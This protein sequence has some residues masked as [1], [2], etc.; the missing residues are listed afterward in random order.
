MARVQPPDHT[1]PSRGGLSECH[2]TRLDPLL[3]PHPRNPTPQPLLGSMNILMSVR[4]TEPPNSVLATILHVRCRCYTFVTTYLAQEEARPGS[5][6]R[7]KHL[8]FSCHQ[9][10]SNS[11]PVV[12]SSIGRFSNIRWSALHAGGQPNAMLS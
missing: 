4:V 5:L 10:G 11:M 12:K 3:A 6:L 7:G 1:H 8:I 9:G 2:N